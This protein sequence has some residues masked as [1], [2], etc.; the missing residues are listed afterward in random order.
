[1]NALEFTNTLAWLNAG[2]HA[3]MA[4]GFMLLCALQARRVGVAGAVLLGATALFDLGM[5]FV[6]RGV[7]AA[8][9]GGSL[10]GTTIDRLLAGQSILGIL[11]TLLSA[12]LTGAALL[13]LREPPDPP[14][15]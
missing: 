7:G 2:A 14:Q 5:V 12:L 13:L 4:L 15:P 8:L 11:V 3:L 10:D 9:R 6:N 1:M